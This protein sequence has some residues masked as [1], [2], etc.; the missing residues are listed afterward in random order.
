MKADIA[1]ALP[2]ELVE[3]VVIRIAERPEI[4]RAA[5]ARHDRERHG[6]AELELGGSELE[7]DGTDERRR[8]D[9]FDRVR[10]AVVARELEQ[11]MAPR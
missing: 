8:D 2:V 4:I 3:L 11:A 9:I 10:R 6:C 5:I 7:A 1:E